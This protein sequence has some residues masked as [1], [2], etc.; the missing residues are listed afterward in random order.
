MAPDRNRV[1]SIPGSSGVEQKLAV[2]MICPYE[3]GKTVREVERE[4][5]LTDVIKLAS[6]ENPLGPSRQV[7]DTLNRGHLDL[8]AYPDYDAWDL[9][10]AIAA[11]LGVSMDCLLVGAGS[12]DLMKLVADAYLA[13]GDEALVSDICFPVYGNVARLEGAEVVTVPLDDDLQYDLE[14]M[15][16]ALTERARLIFLASPNN[17]TGLEIPAAEL[18]RFLERIPPSVLCVLDLAYREYV[19][20]EPGPETD[21]EPLELLERHPNLLLLH[22]FSKVYGLAGLRVGYAVAPTDVIATLGRVRIPFSASTPAQVAGRV[23]LD[24]LEHTAESIRLNRAMRA[25]LARDLQGLGL[26]TW[27]SSANFIL[28]DTGLDSDRVFQSMLRRGIVVRP[29]REPRL[30]TCLRITTGT[31]EQ[32]GRAVGALEEVLKELRG[33]R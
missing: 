21:P 1:L 15:L 6:N 30:D 16:D 26:R 17:P 18:A 33:R 22:T 3:P 23:A 27:P 31:E 20:P 29:V 4:L 12:S 28:V 2:E 19:D 8:N 10:Q 32:V 5:G 11:R 24:D 25:C 13:T 14:R 9:R 7:I